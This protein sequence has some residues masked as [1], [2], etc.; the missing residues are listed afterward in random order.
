MNGK[1]FKRIDGSDCML[2]DIAQYIIK[3]SIFE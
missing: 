3:I 1:P 2:P